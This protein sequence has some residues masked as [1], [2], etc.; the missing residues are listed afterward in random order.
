MRLAGCVALA[1]LGMFFPIVTHA[2]VTG[3]SVSETAEADPSDIST[4]TTFPPKT[5]LAVSSDDANDAIVD[6][7]TYVGPSGAG[8]S[9]ANAFYP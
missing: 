4:H 9:I 8:L 2:S 5:I 7:D 1:T 6:V 3:V